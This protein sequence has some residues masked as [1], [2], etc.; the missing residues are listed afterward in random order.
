M[1]GIGGH[2]LQLELKRVAPNLPVIIITA[3]GSIQTAVESMKLG[4]VRLH[5]QAVQQRRVAAGRFA[6]AGNSQPAPGSATAARRTRAQLWPAQHHRHESAD[7]RGAGDAQADRRQHRQRA[8]DG[9]ERHRQGSAGARAAFRELAPRRPLRPDQ[10][11]GASRDPD[12]KRTVR[13]RPRRFHRRAPRQGPGSS[14]R[15]AAA[16]CSWTRSAR[17]RWACKPSCCASSRTSRSARSARPRK[18][19]STC[20]SSPPP[21]PTSSVCWSRDA[22]DPT[23]TIDSTTLTLAVPPLRDRPEDLPL[24]LKHFLS[25]ASAEA[26]KTPP[27]VEPEAMACLMRYRWPGNMRELHNVLANR[28]PHLRRRQAEGQGFAAE[29]R[30]IPILRPG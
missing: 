14:R 6:R 25:R 7:G 16:R 9:R 11:R 5:H 18:R 30:R 22:S 17:C 3:F 27:E 23:S 1:S 21:T 4:R 26:G 24:L 10:L 20:A 15:P 2:Q 29:H 8:A 28:R 12:R 13:P 19:P